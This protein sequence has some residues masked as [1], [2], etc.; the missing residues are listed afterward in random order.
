MIY[1][2]LVIPA[3]LAGYAYGR[4]SRSDDSPNWRAR[5]REALKHAKGYGQRWV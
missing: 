1:L 2:A 4:F 5:R 3:F